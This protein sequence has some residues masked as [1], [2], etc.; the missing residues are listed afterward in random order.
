M[1]TLIILCILFAG[2][3]TT[4]ST[5]YLTSVKQTGERQSI[6]KVETPSEAE[7]IVYETTGFDFSPLKK[8]LGKKKEYFEFSNGD[9][10]IYIQKK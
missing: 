8:Y 4:K 6:Q 2:C 1:K 9:I 3:S 10:H 7:R 5:I